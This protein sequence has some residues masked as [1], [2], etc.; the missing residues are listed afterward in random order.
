[1]NMITKFTE[2]FPCILLLIISTTCWARVIEDFDG[3][4]LSEMWI[5]SS[6]MVLK[7]SIVPNTVLHEGVE[8]RL[9]KVVASEGGYF[10][11]KSNL[12]SF[13]F[14]LFKEIKFRINA[15]NVSVQKPIVFE[16]QV[17]AAD[18]KA[19]RWRK[20]EITKPGWQT[21]SL[22]TRFFRHSSFAYLKWE[23]TRRFAFRFRNAG[24]VE[25]DKIELVDESSGSLGSQLRASELSRIA[26][27]G[28]DKIFRSGNFY[29]IS[30]V[31]DLEG[32]KILDSLNEFKDLFYSDFP[33]EVEEDFF[34]PLLI[35]DSKKNYQ[36]F[37]SIL[38]EKF[39]SFG[40]LP[41]SDG[42][43]M[44]GIAGSYFDSKLGLVRPVYIH[45]VCHA[46][47]ARRFGIA[48]QGGWLQEGMANYYQLK[49]G[50]KDTRV[51]AKN[52]LSNDQIVP[53]SNLLNGRRVGMK[54]YAQVVL[55]Y[56]WILTTRKKELDAVIREVAK[57]G[58]SN[59]EP[60]AKAYLGKSIVGL[61]KEWI[62]WLKTR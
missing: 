47:I 12:S 60:L 48:S 39:N 19:W 62:Q 27:E 54:N 38:S 31:P 22:P 26:F 20:V 49:W 51:Y 9:L 8:G 4:K 61:E 14:E 13:S 1:M 50:Q 2:G 57:Q 16:F 10:A 52:L 45:E 6:G 42:Y 24:V 35:F 41:R 33:S 25:I 23:Q 32:E 29:I 44:L 43:A 11:T 28:K 34:I 30:N 59:I 36:N 17:F 18:R 56:E 5:A 15:K 55:F 37:W 53:L 58:S 40:P 7:R 46:L 3:D 21:V